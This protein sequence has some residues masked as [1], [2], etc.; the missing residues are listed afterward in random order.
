MTDYSQLSRL[1]REH[2][3]RSGRSQRDLAGELRISQATL[4]NWMVGRRVPRVEN[5]AAIA[6]VLGVPVDS[7]LAAAAG[8]IAHED[9]ADEVDQPNAV[10]AKKGIIR[11][12]RMRRGWSRHD[13]AAAARFSLGTVSRAERGE[14]V[15]ATTLHTIAQ[16]LQVPYE[17]LINTRKIPE[18]QEGNSEPD[19]DIH[20]DP[21]FAP[22]E[23]KDLLT[24]LADYYR[25]CGGAG[26]ELN[27]EAQEATVM[28]PVHV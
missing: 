4:S 20:F 6:K 25:A 9:R 13:L 2:L 19:F 17:D 21:S 26:F 11:E 3:A 10:R 28:E 14:L 16:A 12:L 8:P 18:S 27:L 22:E 5:A 24:A 1:L 23:V 15:R 7:L